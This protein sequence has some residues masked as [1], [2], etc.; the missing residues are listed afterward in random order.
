[1]KDRVGIV[2]E[3]ITALQNDLPKED[4]SLASVAECHDKILEDIKQ[5]LQKYSH[6]KSTFD[7]KTLVDSTKLT[8]VEKDLEEV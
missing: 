3:L 5:M 7:E 6:S 1:L 4:G 8:E 2:R